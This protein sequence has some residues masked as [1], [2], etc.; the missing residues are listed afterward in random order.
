M[1]TEPTRYRLPV[2][3]PSVIAGR[4]S[5]G[6]TVAEVMVKLAAAEAVS[7]T[8]SPRNLDRARLALVLVTMHGT[9]T[10]ARDQ[11]SAATILSDLLSD[12]RHL[13]D[14]LGVDWDELA[15]SIHYDEEVISP[16]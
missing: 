16:E 5:E 9:A 3:A 6:P 11:E 7:Y 14:A 10:G 12:T 1:N 2:Y 13:A 15:S 4:W 8:A